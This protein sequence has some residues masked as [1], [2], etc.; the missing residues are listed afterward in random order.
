MEHLDKTATQGRSFLHVYRLVLWL[1][2]ATM[3]L[4]IMVTAIYNRPLGDDYAQAYETFKAYHETGSLWQALSAAVK[5]TR[6]VY[7][8][9]SGVFFSM[10]LTALCPSFIDYRLVAIPAMLAAPLMITAVFYACGCLKVLGRDVPN[11]A[12]HCAALV[13]SICLILFMPDTTEAIYWYSGMINYTFMVAWAL[14][15]FGMLFKACCKEQKSVWRIIVGSVGAF[16]LG[17]ANHLTATASL[18]LYAF[19]AVYVFAARKPKRYLI[20]FLFLIAGYMVVVMCPGHVYRQ[21][22]AG[23]HISALHAFV[24]SYLEAAR[25]LFKDAR[26][27]IFLLLLLP[28]FQAIVPKLKLSFCYAW[29]TPLASV[30]LLAAHYFPL[31]YTNYHITGR[32]WNTFFIS[33]ILL[34]AVNLLSL[35]GVLNKRFALRSD[36]QPMTVHRWLA[37]GAVV[38]V[39][40]G[41]S[42]GPM[43][44]ECDLP[45]VNLT[46]QLLR[47]DMARYAE[48]YDLIVEEV[49]VHSG[50]DVT[51]SRNPRNEFLCSPDLGEDPRHYFN[52]SF[53]KT[54]GGEG[55]NVFYKDFALDP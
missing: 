6:D 8:A 32:H 52:D 33:T 5:A 44:I 39:I 13:I 19:F 54:H 1:V 25:Y 4:P 18:A 30:S 36:K 27:W 29:L 35:C 47:G 3:V 51:V 10:F 31:I 49:R 50:E 12:V 2:L 40:V 53:G 21:S 23:A 46:I 16:L 15:L 9:R 7:I 24:T 26:W 37:L 20:P 41:L 38:I 42:V 45:P 43:D 34:L 28:A 22:A 17:G 11:I 14:F 48:D 55:T